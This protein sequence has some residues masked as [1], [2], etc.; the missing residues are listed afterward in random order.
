MKLSFTAKIRA[1]ILF[2][3]LI[4]FVQGM[5]IIRTTINLENFDSEKQD[6]QNTIYITWFLQFLFSMILI[7]YLPVFLQKA[8]SEIHRKLKEIALGNYSIEMD[9]SSLQTSMDNEFFSVIVSIKEML[10]SIRTFDALKKDK[11]LEHHHRIKAILTLS[12]EGFIIVDK[13]GN[14]VYTN[15]VVTDIFP[16]LEENVNVVDSNF[17]PDIE[18]NVKKYIVSTLH[19]ESKQESIQFF[20]PNLKRHIGLANAIIRNNEGKAIGAVVAFSNME[21]KR[22]EG[23]K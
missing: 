22:I 18:N 9:L 10:K 11:I 21:K 5:I 19:H 12:K 8:F 1:I 3:L 20:N 6:I 7:F 13:K 16:Q 17:P 14:I 4:S 15:D 23:E 2:L